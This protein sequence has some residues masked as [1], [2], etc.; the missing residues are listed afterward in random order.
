MFLVAVSPLPRSLLLPPRRI[1]AVVYGVTSKG[2]NGKWAYLIYVD[3]DAST[4]SLLLLINLARK[5]RR[6]FEV[7]EIVQ[8]H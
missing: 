6:R 5:E 8:V 1:S 3:V 2:F 4:N 7:S